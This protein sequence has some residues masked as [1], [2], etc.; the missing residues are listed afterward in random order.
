[1]VYDNMVT[2]SRLV[3]RNAKVT[4]ILPSKLMAGVHVEI[5]IQLNLNMKG[6]Q[7]VN[8]VAQVA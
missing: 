8:A 3:I 6:G 5:R 2:I 1:M 7:T 4:I